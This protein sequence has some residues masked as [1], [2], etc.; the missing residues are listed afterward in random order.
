MTA[1]EYHDPE[2]AVCVDLDS[3]GRPMPDTETYFLVP[4]LLVEGRQVQIP[5]REA[6][7]L[8][9]VK[10]TKIPDLPPQAAPPIDARIFRK[11]T[12]LSIL[13]S[14]LPEAV[15]VIWQ[16]IRALCQEARNGL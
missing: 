10:A 2:E 1:H 3:D 13:K 12:D 8:G 14:E 5:Y 11:V 9:L 15:T 6:E 4:G 16:A 7:M